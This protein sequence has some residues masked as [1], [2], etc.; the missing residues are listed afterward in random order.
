MD[1]IP[2]LTAQKEFPAYLHRLKIPIINKDLNKTPRSAIDRWEN[3]Q[4]P[5]ANANEDIHEMGHQRSFAPRR[6]LYRSKSMPNLAEPTAFPS[7]YNDATPASFSMTKPHPRIVLSPVP[8]RRCSLAMHPGHL[9]NRGRR[10][11]SPATTTIKRPNPGRF[12]VTSNM[13]LLVEFGQTTIA[14]MPMVSDNAAIGVPCDLPFNSEPAL[15]EPE[16]YSYMSMRKPSMLS[17][18]FAEKESRIDWQQ[19]Y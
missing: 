12:L 7:S 16:H 6:R 9:A 17:R 2:T 10:Q 14:T 1:C 4:L 19:S 13:D 5:S 8:P 15:V 18:L 3:Q 11:S